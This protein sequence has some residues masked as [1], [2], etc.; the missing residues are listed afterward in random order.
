MDWIRLLGAKLGLWNVVALT[1][2]DGSQEFRR[3]RRSPFGGKRVLIYGPWFW[4][5]RYAALLPDGQIGGCLFRGEPS[6]AAEG[7]KK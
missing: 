6:P 5:V 2:Y 3:V 7:R 4:P 1:W